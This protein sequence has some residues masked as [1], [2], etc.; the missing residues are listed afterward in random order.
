MKFAKSE[1]T[2]EPKIESELD[3]SDPKSTGLSKQ[4]SDIETNS[5]EDSKIISSPDNSDSY[6]TEGSVAEGSVAEGS[7]TEENITEFVQLAMHMMSTTILFRSGRKTIA[8]LTT[9]NQL[10]RYLPMTGEVVEAIFWVEEGR[11]TLT[12]LSTCLQVLR[13]ILP[14]N[15]LTRKITTWL[16]VTLVNLEEDKKHV[17]VEI[18]LGKIYDK[19]LGSASNSR[20]WLDTD[21]WSWIC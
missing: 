18:K 15:D 7:V 2:P 16:Y 5:L 19:A 4:E 12:R 1:A 10:W 17:E 9:W 13:G 3:Q 21:Y 11:A 6:K 14:F 8:L 20:S